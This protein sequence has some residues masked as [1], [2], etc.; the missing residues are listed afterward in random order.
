MK[1]TLKFQYI[2]VAQK[3]LCM[4]VAHLFVSE[5]T[6]VDILCYLLHFDCRGAVLLYCNSV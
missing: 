1:R 5:E 6:L 3:R 4:W 2:Y